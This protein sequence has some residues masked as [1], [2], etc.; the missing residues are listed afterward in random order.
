MLF[1][2]VVTDNPVLVQIDQ[3]HFTGFQSSV[4][5]NIFRLNIYYTCL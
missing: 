5:Q 2:F 4:F 1:N 3:K